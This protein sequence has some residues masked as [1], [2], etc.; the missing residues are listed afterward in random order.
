MFNPPFPSI[1]DSNQFYLEI[2]PTSDT[3]DQSYSTV[4]ACQRA[5][6]NQQCSDA[7]LRWL[8]EEISPNARIYPS[9]A[10]LPSFWEV[11]NGTTIIVDNSRLVLIP[12]LAMDGDELRVPQEWVDIPE[13]VADYYLAVIVN[14]D[15]GWMSIFGYTSHQRLKTMGVYDATD[16]T[17]SLDSEDLIQDINVLWVSRQYSQE[18]LRAEVS[19]LTVLAKTQADNLLQRLGNPDIKFPRLQVPF[20]LWGAFFT[21]GGWRQHLYELRQGIKQQQSIQQSIQQWLQ[22]GVPEFAQKL[23]WNTKMIYLHSGIRSREARILGLSQ[24][25]QIAGNPYELCVFPNGNPESQIWRFEL[26]SLTPESYIPIGFKLRLLTEDLQTF[27][28]N[29]DK[30]TTTTDLLYVEV[31]VGSGEGLVWETEPLPENYNREILRF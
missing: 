25:L 20:T 22:D 15:E 7:F 18:H 19:P 29:E 30:V 31:M 8:R 28:N 5:L 10:T 17:Y 3:V 2:S 14:P 16:R 9:L 1:I 11:V 4:G 13:F 27:E 23:G 6:I 24:Q 21:H 26:R 12:T